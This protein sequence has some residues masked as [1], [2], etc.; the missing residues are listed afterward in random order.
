MLITSPYHYYLNAVVAPCYSFIHYLNI[1]DDIDREEF[2]GRLHY[3]SIADCWPASYI[4]SWYMG[5]G[6]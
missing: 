6:C 1:K 2:I 3:Q 5:R 4:I